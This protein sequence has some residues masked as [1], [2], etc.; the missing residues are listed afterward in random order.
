MMGG[1]IHLDSTVGQGSRFEF[2]IELGTCAGSAEGSQAM[3]LQGARVL[4]LTPDGLEARVLMEM[5]RDLG[6]AA[7]RADDTAGAAA[8]LAA[9]GDQVVLCDRNYHG[10]DGISLSATLRARFPNVRFVIMLRPACLRADLERL[11][12]TGIAHLVKPIKLRELV[13]AVTG[14]AAAD[15][16]GVDSMP[17]IPADVPSPRRHLLLVEDTP[18]NVLLIQAFLRNEPYN[19]DVAENGA[20][21]FEKFRQGSYDLILMDMQMPVMDGYAATAAIRD[22]ER[23]RGAPRTRIIALTAHAIREDIDRCLAAGCDGHLGKP[24]K[25]AVLLQALAEATRT[26]ATVN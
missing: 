21:G 22:F 12:G 5:F 10:E 8:A 25:K 3:L 26:A 23:D 20:I 6:W 24:I 11:A 7:T 15:A 14:N 2:E 17:P 18:D 4:L 16:G 13:G 9:G 19:I 1:K